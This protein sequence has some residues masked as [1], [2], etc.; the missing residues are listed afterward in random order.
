MRF[1]PTPHVL[2][3]ACTN[4]TASVSGVKHVGNRDQRNIR[5]VVLIFVIAVILWTRSLLFDL[6]SQSVNAGIF[7]DVHAGSLDGVLACVRCCV[8]ILVYIVLVFM[9]LVIRFRPSPLLHRK[10]TR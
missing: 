7:V 1:R 3:A 4:I 6:G 2:T 10:A 8:G 5:G 9:M